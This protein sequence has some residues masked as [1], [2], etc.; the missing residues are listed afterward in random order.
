MYKFAFV[1]L[2][3]V[4]YTCRKAIAMRLSC[5]LI[6]LLQGLALEGFSQV[7]KNTPLPRSRNT[8]TK[9]AT[10]ALPNPTSQNVG[11]VIKDLPTFD[12]HSEEGKRLENELPVALPVVPLFSHSSEL[13]GYLDVTRR[14]SFIMLEV[15]LEEIPPMYPDGDAMLT[16]YA[17][18]RQH[19]TSKTDPG[20]TYIEK[21]PRQFPSQSAKGYQHV[22]RYEKDGELW[23]R[24]ELQ[25]GKQQTNPDG[26]HYITIISFYPAIY[27]EKASLEINYYFDNLRINHY[28]K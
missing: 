9:P 24:N 7:S 17:N 16:H 8:V 22:M 5:L 12:D 28:N 23:M 4:S 27:G 11:I 18:F 6:I 2:Y 20:I 25:L 21:I 1:G 13:P 3:R 10:T 19:K 15:F 26:Y 14:M